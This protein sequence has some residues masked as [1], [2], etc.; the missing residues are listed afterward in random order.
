ML[1]PNTKLTS[2][3]GLKEKQE[4]EN[5]LNTEDETV[6][7]PTN[8][9][10]FETFSRVRRDHSLNEGS[11]DFLVRAVESPLQFRCAE[12]VA[13]LLS[14]MLLTLLKRLLTVSGTG[15]IICRKRD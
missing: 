5:D 9:F 14:R 8:C 15:G 2:G 11:E 6:S 12:T 4:N 1:R 7:R 13:V 10:A 3:M